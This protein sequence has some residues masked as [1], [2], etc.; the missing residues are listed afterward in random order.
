MKTYH[1]ASM[2][3]LLS[4]E[5]LQSQE[6]V[7][8]VCDRPC[9]FCQR[10]YE[11]PIDLQQHVAGH[12]EST[13]LLSLPNLDSNAEAS[14]A[15]QVNSNSANRNYA[16]SRADDFDRMEPLVFLEND[17]PADIPKMTETN[18]EL[19]RHKLE[20]E[21]VPFDSMNEANVEAR[22]AYSSG[23]AG[24]W[25]S[26]LSTDLGEDSELLS[27]TRSQPLS[28]RDSSPRIR[29]L[30]SSLNRL[31]SDVHEKCE[32]GDFPDFDAELRSLQEKL[33][34]ARESS[35]LQRLSQ[36]QMSNMFAILRYYEDILTD[37]D[38]M[39]IKYESV[40]LKS[41]RLR[42]RVAQ[43]NTDTIRSRLSSVSSKLSILNA[44]YVT[45]ARTLYEVLTFC[46]F[47]PQVKDGAVG[48][49]EELESSGQS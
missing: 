14:E 23:L 41:R 34:V 7:S 32:N 9:P 8:Q 5:L 20:V 28:K 48:S 26:R 25:L 18:K 13:A 3:H 46:S 2:H 27:E 38:E 33:H 21:S 35:S 30:L 24:E 37:M 15:G 47:L 11:R 10:E 31:Y 43:K 45:P 6:S 29:Q 42:K 39:I 1:A 12:L 44:T 4:S 16:E 19:F 49:R 22:Q 36:T 17:H 40:E